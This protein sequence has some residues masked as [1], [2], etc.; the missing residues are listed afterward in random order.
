MT[1]HRPVLGRARTP[2]GSRARRAGEHRVSDLPQAPERA[3]PD[4]LAQ[5]GWTT[6][7]P[8]TAPRSSTG[9]TPSALHRIGAANDLGS[10]VEGKPRVAF[11]ITSTA[12]PIMGGPVGPRGYRAILA[13]SGSSFTGHR[14]PLRRTQSEQPAPA[15]QPSQLS[16][17][18]EPPHITGRSPAPCARVGR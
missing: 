15:I 14:A 18:S 3:R 11:P 17:R 9:G 10:L 4:Q 12:S 1:F 16:Q 6:P 8:P 2:W 7:L 13:G 5:E